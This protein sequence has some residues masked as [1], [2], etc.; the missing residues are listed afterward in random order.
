MG[1]LPVLVLTVFAAVRPPAVDAQDAPS[2]DRWTGCWDV[3][4]GEWEPPGPDDSD[5]LYYR[6]PPRVQLTDDSAPASMPLPSG[7][8]W[9]QMHPAP[10]SL[11]SLH[12]ITMWRPI[13]AD[14]VDILWSSGGTS[15]VFGTLA[16]AGDTLAGRFET[17]TDFSAIPRRT[18]QGRLVRVSC[19]A[20]PEVPASS[21]RPVFRAVPLRNGDTVTLGRPVSD[22]LDSV[23]HTEPRDARGV[24]SGADLIR[25]EDTPCG[26]TLR[27]VGIRYQRA[28]ELDSLVGAWSDSLGEPVRGGGQTTGGGGAMWHNRTTDLW[29]SYSE[30]RG[31]EVMLLDPRFRMS[32]CRPGPGKQR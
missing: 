27:E 1:A 22:R 15:G 21:Q 8:R 32:N 4:R 18:T 19:S 13:G 6:P 12:S 24:F 10:G 7:E 11:P 9:M 5:S 16:A 31:V 29:V 23:E 17:I 25:V 30:L 3:E 20:P 2:A 14:S 26:D 28:V